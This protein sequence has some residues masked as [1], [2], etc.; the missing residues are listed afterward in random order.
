MEFY[1][2]SIYW[3]FHDTTNQ[4]TII[5][6]TPTHPF[7]TFSTSLWMGFLKLGVEL[8]DCRWSCWR[9]VMIVKRPFGKVM[10]FMEVLVS[11]FDWLVVWNMI[12]V[13]PYVGNNHP[14]WPIFF[15]GVGQPP[16]REVGITRCQIRFVRFVLMSR[17][18]PA[19]SVFFW[20]DVNRIQKTG[21]SQ[22][23]NNQ[24]T[25]K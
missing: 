22:W 23:G 7:P 8:H 11:K 5:P 12:F 16:T 19:N 18:N 10:E 17:R 13:S 14:N 21:V 20:P 6:A 4:S 2:F 15:R 25:G 24:G 1:D 3:E 9:T